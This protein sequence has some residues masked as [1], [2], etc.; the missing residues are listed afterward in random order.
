ME[1]QI[2]LPGENLLNEVENRTAESTSVSPEACIVFSWLNG[3]GRIDLRAGE[4]A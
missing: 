3:V 1:L 2:G 4:T